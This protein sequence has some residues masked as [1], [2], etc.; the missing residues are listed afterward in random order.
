M[1]SSTE[2]IHPSSA[3]ELTG[4]DSQLT[5]LPISAESCE[6][7]PT[8]SCPPQESGRSSLLTD[9]WTGTGSAGSFCRASEVGEVLIMQVLNTNAMPDFHRN[10]NPGTHFP[11]KFF[12]SPLT[13][14]QPAQSRSLWKRE[15]SLQRQHPGCSHPSAYKD[16][17]ENTLTVHSGCF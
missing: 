9:V 10:P 11:V 8:S 3:S 4:Q 16:R 7:I 14:L 5:A 15:G 1:S 13:F 12:I 17:T 6:F 2:Q